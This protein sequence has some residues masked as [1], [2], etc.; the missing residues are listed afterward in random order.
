MKLTKLVWYF[1]IFLYFFQILQNLCFYRKR[2]NERKGKKLVW[3]WSIPQQSRPNMKESAQVKKRSPPREAHS[4]L[5]ILHQK[6]QY[7]FKTINALPPFLSLWHLYIW[8]PEFLSIL[9]P[10]PN[11]GWLRQIDR[12]TNR[13]TEAKHETELDLGL[14]V[15]IRQE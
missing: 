3:A 12:H 6:P 7:I 8:N 1:L 2:E 5:D 4:G 15:K 11:L 10:A 14:D 13:H 9:F